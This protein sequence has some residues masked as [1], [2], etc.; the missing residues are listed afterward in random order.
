[1]H[2]YIRKPRHT[3]KGLNLILQRKIEGCSHVNIRY[4]SIAGKDINL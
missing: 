1:V 4:G 3:M 2:S